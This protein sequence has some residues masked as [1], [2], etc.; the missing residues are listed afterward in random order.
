MTASQDSRESTLVA[1]KQRVKISGAVGDQEVQSSE[2][3]PAIPAV[4]DRQPS[5]P[6]VQPKLRGLRSA[7][8]ASRQHARMEQDA[9]E[10][11]G[12]TDDLQRGGTPKGSQANIAGT[13]A[14]AGRGSWH[15]RLIHTGSPSPAK[16]C[17][18]AQAYSPANPTPLTLANTPPLPPPC[19]C[20]GCQGLQ[21][22]ARARSHADWHCCSQRCCKR[23]PASLPQKAKGLLQPG[24][25]G[26][27]ARR[28]SEEEYQ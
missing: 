22:A 27:I 28:E 15:L 18:A 5:H 6:I 12:G 9:E 7:G 25:G 3:I 13:V 17:I 19:T 11:V 1:K 24:E 2:A 4:P 8:A 26:N 21:R 23:R 16:P 14:A 20:R 10:G